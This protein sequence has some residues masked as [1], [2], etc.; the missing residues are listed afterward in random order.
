[1]DQETKE[2]VSELVDISFNS[3]LSKIREWHTLL[4]LMI[5]EIDYHAELAADKENKATDNNMDLED[6]QSEKLLEKVEQLKRN[7]KLASQSY[8]QNGHYKDKPEN[9]LEAK[10]D[11]RVVMPLLD[12]IC[13]GTSG[14][15]TPKL[16]LCS[17]RC[18]TKSHKKTGMVSWLAVPCT[19]PLTQAT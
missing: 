13:G 12:H 6:D 7:L 1:M 9:F 10:T 19:Y 3:L 18:Q 15:S 2:L 17:N 11:L 4:T 5:D 16:C 8:D 14:G